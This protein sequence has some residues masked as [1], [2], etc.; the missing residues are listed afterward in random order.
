VRFWRFTWW[1]APPKV[2]P[3]CG[4]IQIP[5]SGHSVRALD[6]GI[7]LGEGAS[8]N[9]AMGAYIRCPALQVGMKTRSSGDSPELFGPMYVSHAPEPDTMASSRPSGLIC[10]RPCCPKEL[11]VMEGGLSS[12]QGWKA[13]MALAK[14]ERRSYLWP[15]A[16]RACL[17][18]VR[19]RLGRQRQRTA[20]M[21]WCGKTNGR[22]VMVPL[23]GSPISWPCFSCSAKD[24]LACCR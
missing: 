10:S 11:P 6:E 16:G 4:A 8:S 24:A 19:R 5:C 23:R 3:R 18:A 22:I 14:S 21:V 13:T 2:S 7:G 1:V 15:R 12:R 9:Q 17:P 20:V